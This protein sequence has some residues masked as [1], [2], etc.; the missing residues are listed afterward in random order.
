VEPKLSEAERRIEEARR[1]QARSLDLGDLGLR[2]LPA[3]LGDLPHLETLFLGIYWPPEARNQD[4]EQD[5]VNPE[6]ADLAPLIGL[7]RL[8]SLDLSRTG[9]TDISDLAGLQGL[10]NLDLSHTAVTD[11]APLANLQALQ[12]LTL[13][14]TGVTDLAPL[15]GLEGLQSLD[16]SSTSV[17]DPTPLANLQALQRLNLSNTGVTDVAPLAGLEELQSLDLSSTSVINLTPLA[18]LQALQSLNLSNTGVTDV[19]QLA[20]LQGLQGLDLSHTGVT[21]L[22]PLP[23][24]QGLQS[25][26]LSNTS[27]TDLTPLASLQRLQSL[28]L[29]HT[30]VTNLAP[31]AGLQELWS[32]DLSRGIATSLVVRLD[33]SNMDQR[34]GLSSPYPGVTDLEPLS[35]LQGLRR[36]DLSGTDVTNLA[37]LAGLRGLL[38]LLLN[39]TDVTDLAPLAGLHGLQS[40][41]LCHCPGVT[42]L[43]PLSGLRDLKA[44]LLWNTSVADLA[45]LAGLKGLQSLHLAVTHV[46]D[47]APLAGLVGLQSLLLPSGPTDLA[48]LAG[49]QGLQSLDLSGAGVTDLAPLARLH[50]LQRLHLSSTSVTDLAPLAGLQGL[51]SLYL[52]GGAGVTDLAPLAGL[53]GLQS[54]H[55]SSTGVTDLAPLA[56]LNGLQSLDVSSTGVT[57]LA[58]LA[59]L[60]G[61]QVLRMFSAG[62]TDL[63]PLARLQ[64]IRSLDLGYCTDVTDLAPLAGLRGLQRLNL[65]SCTGLTNLAP[66]AG[67]QG[68]QYL[69]IDH[70]PGLTDLAPLAGLHGLQ[71]LNLGY[72]TSV[73]DV[74][75]LT[76]IKGLQKIGLYGCGLALPPQIVRAFAHHSRLMNLDAD[77]ALGVPREVLS[78]YHG[79][80]CLPRLRTYLSELELGG[81][82]ENE[83]KVILL[84]NGRVGKTQ[85][86]RRLRDHAFDESVESTHGVQIWREEWRVQT[87]DQKKVFRVNWWDFG[88]QDIYHGTHAL[89]LRSRAVFLILWTPKLENRN[90]YSED[91]TILRNQPLAYWLAYVRSLAGEGSP[92]IVVQSQCDRFADR[93]SSPPRPGGFGFFESCSYSAKN[94]LGRE[95]LESHL[96]DAMRY[97]VERNGAPEI[98]RGRSEV[99]RRLYDWRSKDQKRK[100]EKRRHRTLSL[101]EFQAVCDDIGG[102]VS[103]EDALD[104]F[105]HTGV[106][107]YRPDLFSNCI[108]LDQD[109]ALDAVYTVFHR[110]RTAPWLEEGRFT[111]KDLSLMVWKEGGHSPDEQRLFLGLMESCGVCF[112]YG[113]TAG[114]EKRYVAP[115]L[116]P[117]FEA[118]RLHAWDKAHTAPTLRME[119]RF[120]HPAVVRGLMSEIGRKAEGCAVYWKYGLWFQDDRRDTQILVQFEDTS[121]NEVPGAGALVL[122]AQG[123]DALGILGEMRKAILRQQIGDEP[124]ELLTLKEGTTVARTAVATLIGGCVLDLNAN[125]VPATAFCAFFNDRERRL[126]EVRGTGKAPELDINPRPLTASEKPREVFIS[127]AWGDETPKGRIRAQAV[128]GL[129]S[130]LAGDGFV[131]VRDRE[132]IEPGDRISPFIRR[133]TRGD[134]VVAVISDKYLRSPY[135]MYEIYSLWQKYQGDADDLAQHLVPIVLPEVRIGS[136]EEREPYVRYWIKR[137]KKQAPVMRDLGLSASSESQ[138]EA[139]LVQAFAQHVDEILVFLKDILMPRKLDIHLDDDFHL[140][141]DALRKRMRMVE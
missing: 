74:A 53:H 37:V 130:A 122:K 4:W 107:F 20:G 19:A 80:N 2:E 75:P 127:Y 70:C 123:G 34:L 84:G 11:L 71:D 98:G 8:H 105:H 131:P 82:P 61:L 76:E 54:L 17:M 136:L 65:G 101:V 112:P 28:N 126:G 92:V 56:G 58:P 139:R 51:Q 39:F 99:R 50:G 57:N 7:Q 41:S 52:S 94:D 66:L 12:S 9:V 96:R 125:L 114:G 111:R 40:L 137:S 106:V 124:E 5:P 13:P 119:Y 135:C 73:T 93:R 14:H 6:L 132:H 110:G 33:L 55:L 64:R 117:K 85:L 90:E 91:G 121:A 89:F 120:F 26:N 69:S 97:L 77:E 62:V 72:C 79:D 88:G 42:D 15:A 43:A 140:V 35:R 113:K 134:F 87:G 24:L 128:E 47:L 100:P 29:S 60:E 21:D 10:R 46:R 116:L 31:L 102:I 129:Y 32:L 1:D 103:W 68:V 49:L 63:E 27:V 18:S 95:T 133:L 48:P 23:R 16:L 104:Y 45:P 22:A 30:G 36:L 138:R 81:E 78:H 108:V 115:D 109:W 141:R 3:S 44:L 67:L 86:C 118:I 38:S 25:L 59:G 83:V